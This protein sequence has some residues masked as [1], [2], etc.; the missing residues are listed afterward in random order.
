M[1]LFFSISLVVGNMINGSDVTYRPRV[2]IDGIPTTS[3]DYDSM[4]ADPDL[5]EY[6]ASLAAC[7]RD[8]LRAKPS[9]WL[10]TLLNG[11][12][13]MCVAYCAKAVAERQLVPGSAKVSLSRTLAVIACWARPRLA[14]LDA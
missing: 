4:A 11:Y 9:A 14:W 10:A 7:D 12:N 1:D 13:A 2:M 8:A 6:L 5:T 3:F